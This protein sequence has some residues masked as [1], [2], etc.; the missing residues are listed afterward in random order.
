MSGRPVAHEAGLFVVVGLAATAVHVGVALGVEAVTSAGPLIANLCGYLCAVTVS[1]LGNAKATFR[2]PAAHAGQFG[3]FL[4][5][6]LAGLALN[7]A[8]IFVGVSGL[9]WPFWAALIP[10]VIVVPAASFLMAKLWAFARPP[11]GSE[12]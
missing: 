5:A 9:G 10:A 3:R 4:A 8:I 6:S 2:R 12:P 1:Y 11:G 7:Q